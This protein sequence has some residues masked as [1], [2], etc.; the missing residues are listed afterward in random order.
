MSTSEFKPTP[1]QPTPDRSLIV[2]G[3]NSY[4]TTV[5]IETVVLGNAWGRWGDIITFISTAGA[6]KSV[7]CI[8]CVIAWCLGLMY[9]GIKPPRPLRI[10]MFLGEDDMVTFGQCRDGFLEHSEAITG[11]KL[12]AVDL[13][14]LDE[15][16]RTEYSREY[17]G[18][19]FHAYLDATLT[20]F[21]ADLVVVNPLLSYIGGEIV[22]NISGWMRGG[23]MPVIQR[24]KCLAIFPHHTPKMAADG[25]ETTDDVY[26]GIG[27]GEVANIPR[28][29]LTLRPTPVEGL[30]VVKVSKRQTTGWVDEHGDFTTS[31]FVRRSGNP[32]RP[33]WLP[34]PH[35]EALEI[36][37]AAKAGKGVAAGGKKATP[38][39]VVAILQNEAVN[40]QALI[41][42]LMV[43]CDCCEKTAKNAI[44]LAEKKELISSFTEP[45]LQGGHPLRWFCL[46]EHLSQWVK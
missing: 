34:V 29:I 32:E 10:L 22:A 23:I 15:R 19:K 8:Q 4:P 42:D 33:A 27:G 37:A 28:S 11:R 16:L 36:L 46:P 41:Q 6:G 1:D 7:A 24:H 21:P 17:V 44:A 30:S 26:S 45:N 12:T 5:P 20:E 18:D 2:Y 35:G 43:A 13:A 39:R 9:F 31:Y 40:N 3:V 25:W 14:P 38:E